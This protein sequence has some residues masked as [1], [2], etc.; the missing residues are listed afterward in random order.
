MSAISEQFKAYESSEFLLTGNDDE[1]PGY[2]S[3]VSE[4]V[5]EMY[6]QQE[7]SFWTAEEIDLAQDLADWNNLNSD[8]Q[9]FI[10]NVLAFFAAR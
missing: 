2:S 7:A 1:N 8:E 3:V 6:K 9:H 5:W 4:K 10:K